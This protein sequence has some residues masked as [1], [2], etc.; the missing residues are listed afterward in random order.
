[1]AVKMLCI[2][3]REQAAAVGEKVMYGLEELKDS[4]YLT[5]VIVKIVKKMS[6]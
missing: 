1:M 5:V 2:P 6:R 3:D 4:G